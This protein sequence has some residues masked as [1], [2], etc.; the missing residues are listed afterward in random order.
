LAL[1]IGGVQRIAIE[2]AASRKVSALRAGTED[3]VSAASPGLQAHPLKSIVRRLPCAGCRL[4]PGFAE[5]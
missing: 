4:A 1:R 5:G 3:R 2:A